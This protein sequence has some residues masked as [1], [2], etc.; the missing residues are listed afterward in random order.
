MAVDANVPA[1]LGNFRGLSTVVIGMTV[2]A[3]PTRRQLPLA[4]IM[5]AAIAAGLLF[6]GV[7]TFLNSTRKLENPAQHSGSRYQP[8]HVIPAGGNVLDGVYRPSGAER[9]W[10]PHPLTTLSRCSDSLPMTG[11]MASNTLRMSSKL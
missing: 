9:D 8:Q 1:E 5:L 6:W 11:T 7:R 10:E 3:N 2:Q 4:L